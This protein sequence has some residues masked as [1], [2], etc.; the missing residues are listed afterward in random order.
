MRFLYKEIMELM[1]FL[2]RQFNEKPIPVRIQKKDETLE[3]AI[4]SINNSEQAKKK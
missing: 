1:V 4:A 2:K 3:N